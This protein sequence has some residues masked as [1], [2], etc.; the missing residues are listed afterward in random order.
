MGIEGRAHRRK[1]DRPSINF[2]IRANRDASGDIVK[3]LPRRAGACREARREG[4][5]GPGAPAPPPLGVPESPP[6]LSGL[7]HHPGGLEEPLPFARANGNDG[8]FCF[9]LASSKIFTRSLGPKP[10]GPMLPSATPNLCHP[11]T[12]GFS[13]SPCLLGPCRG[14]APQT[15]LVH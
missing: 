1:L 7:F 3:M 11:S 8:C 6:L 14:E 12:L 9:T 13:G 15:A 5:P 10:V 4:A 2:S